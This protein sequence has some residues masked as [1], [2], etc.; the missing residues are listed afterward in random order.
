VHSK[1]DPTVHREDPWLGLD[2]ARGRLDG[3]HHGHSGLKQQTCAQ[4]ERNEER[5]R[6]RYPMSISLLMVFLPLSQRNV[7]IARMNA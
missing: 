2:L 1:A 3:T 7:E 4:G 5:D 6:N